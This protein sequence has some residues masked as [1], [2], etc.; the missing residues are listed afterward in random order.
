MPAQ[1]VSGAGSR[2]PAAIVTRHEDAAQSPLS[3]KAMDMGNNMIS[4][5]LGDNANQ[6]GG[7][8]TWGWIIGKCQNLEEADFLYRIGYDP[9]GR[10]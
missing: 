4:I 3:E 10:A 5:S 1:V 6:H 9:S 7:S 8:D 2:G